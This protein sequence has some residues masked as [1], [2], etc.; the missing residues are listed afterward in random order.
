[1]FHDQIFDYVTRIFRTLSFL[2]V[3]ICDIDFLGKKDY[4][5][6]MLQNGFD[7]DKQNSVARKTKTSSTVKSAKN[8]RLS[9]LVFEQISADLKNE[10]EKSANPKNSLIIFLKI[11]KFTRSH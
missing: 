9:D 2:P 3:K 4:I 5:H 11:L 8:P 10:I 6:S 1:M 7:Q